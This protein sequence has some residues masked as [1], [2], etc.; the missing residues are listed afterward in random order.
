MAASDFFSSS[1][2]LVALDPED[3]AAAATVTGSAI[4]TRGWRWAIFDVIIG[5]AAGS[6]TI[7]IEEDDNSGFS[8]GTDVTGASV[9]YTAASDDSVIRIVIDCQ[10]R[11]RYLR[12]KEITNATGVTDLAALCTLYL[13][14]DTANSA[15]TTPDATVLT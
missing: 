10:Q 3:Y 5:D 11:E 1:K 6:G 12:I 15:A 8:S 14:K 13:A 7:Q 4:D 2:A 9:A